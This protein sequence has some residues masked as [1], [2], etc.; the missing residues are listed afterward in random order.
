MNPI[1]LSIHL[2]GP[3]IPFYQKKSYC[4]VKENT[5]KIW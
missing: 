1:Y 5:I 3:G 2:F 4:Q